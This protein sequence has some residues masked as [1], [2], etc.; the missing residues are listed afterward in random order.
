MDYREIAVYGTCTVYVN[1][2]HTSSK[3]NKKR[4]KHMNHATYS[5]IRNKNL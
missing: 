5:M 4:I 1:L 2:P 3:E